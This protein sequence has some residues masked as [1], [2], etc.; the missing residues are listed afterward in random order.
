PNIWAGYGYD[1]VRVAAKAIET[2]GKSRTPEALRE[3]L[4]QI[5]GF[6]GVTGMV[7]FDANGDVEKE[8]NILV[9]KNGV[10]SYDAS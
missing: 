5:S 3:A 2:A 4:S 1:V 6:P 10:R 7:T 8:L 9:V